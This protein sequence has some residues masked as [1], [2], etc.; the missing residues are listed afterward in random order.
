MGSTSAQHLGLRLRRAETTL[1]SAPM[2]P[3]TRRL[4]IVAAVI[5]TIATAACGRSESYQEGFKAGQRL[6]TLGLDA[7]AA[8]KGAFILSS[9]SDRDEYLKGCEDGLQS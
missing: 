7:G 1:C 8:C 2:K 6:S 9:A 3:T 5:V 4:A